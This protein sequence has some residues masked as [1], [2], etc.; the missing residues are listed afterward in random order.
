[1]SW[2]KSGLLS[3]FISIIII[4]L[5]DISFGFFVFDS[6]IS[7]IVRA[8]NRWIV[9]REYD[10]DQRVKI[11]INVPRDYYENL[12][13]KDYLVNVDENGFIS[14]GNE[15]E[16]NVDIKVAFFG[17]ST[18]ES[19]LVDEKMRFTSHVERS[20]RNKLSKNV[21]VMN[22]GV[23]GNNSMHSNFSLLAKGVPLNLDVAVLMHNMNDL[24]VVART[25]SYW[26]APES[27]V[28][29]ANR[30]V[31]SK[32][33][34]KVIYDDRPYLQKLAKKFKDL[35]FPYLYDYIKPRLE[36][37]FG[38][39]DE[40]YESSVDEFKDIRHNKLDLGSVEQFKQS[41]ETFISI[42]QAWKIKPVLMTQANRLN[43]DDT[44]YIKW[45]RAWQK[46]YN[47]R[48][49]I[50]IFELFNDAIREVAKEEKVLL[51]DLASHIP[52]EPA[53]MYDIVHLTKKGS[54]LASDKIV[55]TM[56]EANIFQ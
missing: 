5:I 35:L 12:E 26:N 44:F 29:V 21:K 8:E 6:G 55:E 37:R 41:L 32:K 20:L 48:E 10:P 27:R 34:D 54:K 42:C 43:I 51:I 1:M 11:N 24:A 9:L 16:E 47:H 25:K 22:A 52:Q 4:K 28:I 50:Y 3:V 40:T 23:A 13:Y 18:T 33:A 46:Q 53:Y 36:I 30:D 49:L 39:I 2:I 7:K 17:G 15:S 31:K 38:L 14:T 45:A 19:I 56:L